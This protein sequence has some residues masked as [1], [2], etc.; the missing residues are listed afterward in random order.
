MKA[1]WKWL[2]PWDMPSDPVRAVFWFLRWLLQVLV[3][4]FYVLILVGVAYETYLNG[5]VG[6]LGTLLVGLFVWAGLA[7]LLGIVKLTTGF[8]QVYSEI[9][10]LNQ[11]TH[12]FSNFPRSTPGEEENVVEGSIITDL[13]EERRRRRQEM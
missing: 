8:S 12:T 4:Y 9:S 13:D 2:P 7:L 3:R 10:R 5:I 6:L 1:N 11:K